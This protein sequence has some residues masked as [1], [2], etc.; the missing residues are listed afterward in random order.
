MGFSLSNLDP[1]TGF[2]LLP[3]NPINTAL[4]AI[5]GVGQYLGTMDANQANRDIANAAN[6]M[7]VQEAQKNRDFQSEQAQRQ[8]DYQTGSI[9]KQMDYQTGSV[10]KQM[11]FQERMSSSAVQRRMDD[12]KKAGIN[13]ILAGKYDASTP[14]G[15]AMSGSS[16]SGASG[17]GSQASIQKANMMPAYID[18]LAVANGL[19]DLRKKKAETEFTG[20]KTDLTDLGLKIVDFLEGI[21]DKIGVN[22]SGSADVQKQIDEIKLLIKQQPEVN[23]IKNSPG[24]EVTPHVRRSQSRLR[25]KQANDRK[26]QNTDKIELY[27]KN[28]WKQLTE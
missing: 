16:G 18:S 24:I 3:G 10:A 7:Q 8:M 25:N 27:L 20:R 9:Q 13:P 11:G 5:P 4:S 28:M 12:M 19:M 1:T 15:S 2:G 17:S 6:V 26:K 22:A 23:K 14:A 21:A